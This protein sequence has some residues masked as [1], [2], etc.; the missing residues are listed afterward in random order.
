MRKI[1]FVNRPH[2]VLQQELH[3]AGYACELAIDES[4]ASIQ[5]RIDSYFG[6]VINSRFLL[7]KPF[8]EKACSLKFIARVGSGMESIDTEYAAKKGILCFNSPEGNRD[9]VGEHTIGLLLSVMNHIPRADRQVRQLQWFRA[10]NSGSEIKGKTVGIIGY[11]NMGAAFAQR[12]AGFEATVI[13]YDKYKK[14]FSD[15]YAKEVSLGELQRTA[16]IISFHV[17]LTKETHY[18]LDKDF[19]KKCEKPFWLLNT[20]RG[21][22]VNTAALVKAL[23]DGNILG[24]GL[25]VLE[26]EDISFD[27]MGMDSMPFPL[28]ELFTC[29]NVVF[30]PH[31]AGWT[32]ESKYKLAKVLVDKILAAFP[33]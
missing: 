31:V 17:P 22:V 2:P 10:P 30:T 28:Q 23:K 18:Y 21:K 16:D 27:E 13:A 26:Y 3:A 20:C 8:L 6:L 29:E 25:D 33:I 11:G 7:D 19:I 14:N 15:Q 4:K 9:A 32:S 5:N 24:A 1:I 12:L